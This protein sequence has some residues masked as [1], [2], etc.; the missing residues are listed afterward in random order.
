M[1]CPVKNCTNSTSSSAEKNLSWHRFP[2]EN[3]PRRELWLEQCEKRQYGNSMRVCSDHFKK[4]DFAV[5]N[6]KK[7]A[8][9]PNAVPQG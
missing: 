7:R 3:N 6:V 4:T 1:K 5:F 2:T 9:K 8:L